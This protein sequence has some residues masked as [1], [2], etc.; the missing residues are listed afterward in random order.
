M[1]K[2]KLHQHLSA[3]LKT[4]GKELTDIDAEL[5]FADLEAAGISWESAINAL[6]IYRRS[7]GNKFAPKI[8]DI[9]SIIFG[10]DADKAEIAW[11]IVQDTIRAK[12]MYRD[13]IFDD[14]RIMQAVEASGGWV[15]MCT[16]DISNEVA[17]RAAF[18][19][20]YKA[21]NGH[22]CRNVLVGKDNGSPPAM[23]GDREKCEWI[24]DNG[25]K[26]ST[27]AGLTSGVKSL[28]DGVMSK[29]LTE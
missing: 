20:C 11:G 21:V 24:F 15:K 25:S 19:N 10:T 2:Q 9:V 26:S 27:I 28:T 23:I 12:G 13:I 22:T 7:A 1:S 14:P 3:T 18:R 6:G 16:A 5:W 4:Y 8:S 29:V 17:D